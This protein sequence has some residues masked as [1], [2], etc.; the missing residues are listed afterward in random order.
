MRKLSRLFWFQNSPQLG[1]NSKEESKWYLPQSATE[2]ILASN[3]AK[4]STNV[5][6]IGHIGHMDIHCH[7]QNAY[8]YL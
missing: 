6:L 5:L 8:T 3:V 4:T 2:F 7:W 1:I